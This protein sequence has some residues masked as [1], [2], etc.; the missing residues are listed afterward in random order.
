MIENKNIIV[1]LMPSSSSSVD[2]LEFK[3]TIK[4]LTADR[5]AIELEFTKPDMVSI[6]QTKDII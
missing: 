1:S 5:M 2:Q 4:E 3:W 6:Y